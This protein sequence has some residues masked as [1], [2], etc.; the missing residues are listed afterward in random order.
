MII[1]FSHYGKTEYEIK[2]KNVKKGVYFC[3]D[4]I[5]TGFAFGVVGGWA[6]NSN[7]KPGKRKTIAGREPRT[8]TALE[9]QKTRA[10]KPPNRG[11]QYHLINYISRPR[12]RQEGKRIGLKL[13]RVV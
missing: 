5:H 8:E 11:S 7:T 1:D 4:I 3:A 12:G 9:G 2:L 13:Y 10:G 6:T